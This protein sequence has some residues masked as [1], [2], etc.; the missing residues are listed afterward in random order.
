MSLLVGPPLP[1]T[2]WADL[3]TASQE[4]KLAYLTPYMQFIQNIEP[5][6]DASCEDPN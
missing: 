2:A 6:V 3:S 1:T 4:A 5:S